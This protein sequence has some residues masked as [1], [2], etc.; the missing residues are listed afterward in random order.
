MRVW[1]RAPSTEILIALSSD[2]DWDYILGVTRPEEDFQSV[3]EKYPI[4]IRD[5]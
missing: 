5:A 4:P 3:V 2:N 1:A